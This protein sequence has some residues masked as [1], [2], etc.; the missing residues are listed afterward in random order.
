MTIIEAG[1]RHDL[2]ETT[3]ALRTLENAPLRSASR[4]EWVV[5]LRY[6]YADLLTQAGRTTEAIE[7]FHRTAAIDANQT[8]DTTHRLTQLEQDTR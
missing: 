3:S 4:E 8:T 6:A 5:R 2:G 7:W 1:A